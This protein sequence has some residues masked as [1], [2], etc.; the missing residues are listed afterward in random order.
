MPVT[1]DVRS[2]ADAAVIDAAYADLRHVDAI[3]SP[4]RSDSEVSRINAGALV[5]ADAD[6]LVREVLALCDRYE[7]LTRGYFSPWRERRLDPSGLVKGWAIARVA[8]LLDAAGSRDYFVDAGGDVLTRGHAEPGQP[9]RVGVRHPVERDKV[10][11]VILASDLAV[12]T[13]GTY[14][15]GEHIWDPH[16]GAAATALLSMT[17][18]GPDIITAD[19]LATAAFAM[20]RAGLDLVAEQPGYDAF[21]IGHD[22]RGVWTS[23][24]ETRCAPADLPIT[25]DFPG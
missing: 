4:F 3:F 6:P 10:A 9:W 11:R 14:E 21:A 20:G 13:S 16:T 25:A 22:L 23:G 24:F 19:V 18:V 15:K 17:V 5:I 7:A 1:I 2:N 12:A 8:A